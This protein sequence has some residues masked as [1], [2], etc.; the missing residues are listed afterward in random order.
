MQMK[1]TRHNGR[2]GKHGAYNPKHNDRKFDL[3]NSD[4]IDEE[5]AKRNIYWDC[6]QGFRT[7][8]TDEPEEQMVHSFEE[9]ERVFYNE[10]Y[11]DFCEAQHERN[12]KNG[13]PERNKSP[14]DLRTNKKTCP[15]E[16]LIQIGTMEEHEDVFILSLVRTG[17]HS[18]LLRM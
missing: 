12:Q 16:S 7:A 18:R 9:V 1:L 11:F 15:E 4:H 14:D 6:Y 8:E 5:R 13:H 17:S 10:R 3:K 2:S